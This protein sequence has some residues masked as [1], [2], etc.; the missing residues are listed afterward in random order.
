M[1]KTKILAIVLVLIIAFSTVPFSASAGGD[2]QYEMWGF[3][4]SDD[5]EWTFIDGDGDG[6][7]F[8]VRE[9]ETNY[10]AML[11]YSYDYAEG[12]PLYPDNYAISPVVQLEAGVDELYLHW[13]PF[14]LDSSWSHENYSVYVYTG[15]ETLDADNIEG[16]LPTASF[17]ETLPRGNG[18]F[19]ERCIDITQYAGQKVRFVFRHHDVSDVFCLGIDSI[20]IN[21]TKLV[22]HIHQWSDFYIANETHHWHRCEVNGCPVCTVDENDG[23]DEHSMIFDYDNSYHWEKCS[24]CENVDEDTI[25]AHNFTESYDEVTITY[26]CEDCGA[27]F[28]CE[29]SALI[30]LPI[31]IDGSELVGIKAPVGITAEVDEER[32]SISTDSYKWYDRYWNPA[33][34]FVDG[35][36]Y[37]FSFT[38]TPKTGYCFPY[39]VSGED[40][41][42]TAV[43][44]EYVNVFLDTNGA[45]NFDGR[46]TYDSE[47]GIPEEKGS[48]GDVNGDGYIDNIDAVMILKYDVGIEG[49]TE[50]ELADADVNGDGYADNIDASMILKYD[51]GII[52]SFQ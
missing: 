6:H 10:F 40:L 13:A 12:K 20:S 9:V 32:Y 38:V 36:T 15:S 42:V 37:Y 11:S 48:L 50:G 43:E 39:I 25:E 24:V 5:S 22:S 33:T 17:S 21:T 2:G 46:I 28:S 1:K 51:A 52:D 19:Y 30:E 8:I 44:W 14:G 26:T 47:T 29:R 45:L 34:E 35:E 18:I 3:D 27:L 23:Y 4:G 7:S 41:V 16:L 49:L 31:E